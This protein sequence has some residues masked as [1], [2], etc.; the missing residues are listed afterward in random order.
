M[1]QFLT[2]GTKSTRFQMREDMFSIGDDFWIE[3]DSGQRIFKVDNKKLLDLNAYMSDLSAPD[4]ANDPDQL[5]EDDEM[6][7][8]QTEI[9]DLTRRA[10]V[11]VPH[12]ASIPFVVAAS[13]LIATVPERTADLFARHLKLQ[14]L[15][16]PISIPPFRLFRNAVFAKTKFRLSR[17]HF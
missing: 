8:R 17:P 16:V 10:A 12:F 7:E 6:A 9:R 13:D 14:V 11:I 1:N 15:S 3:D 5:T 2:D 4:G